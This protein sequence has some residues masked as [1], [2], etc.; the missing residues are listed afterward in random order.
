MILA[1]YGADVIKVEKPGNSLYQ[2]FFHALSIYYSWYQGHGDDTRT[3]GPPFVE[4]QSTYF[5]SVNRNKRSI[6][7]DMGH[8]DGQNIIR[9]V[10]RWINQRKYSIIFW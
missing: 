10:I 4:D 2:F 3:W 7:I 9:Q 8:S 6:A 1:D 5:L